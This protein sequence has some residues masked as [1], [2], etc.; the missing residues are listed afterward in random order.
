M[1]G[2]NDEVNGMAAIFAVV[3]AGV[4]VLGMFVFAIMVV[5]AAVL[6]LVA[7]VAWFKPLTLFGE[8]VQPEEARWFVYRGVIGMIGV[9]AFVAF[10]AALYG[11]HIDEEVWA[12]LYLGGYVVGS[13]GIEALKAINENE[14]VAV[15]PPSPSPLPPKQIEAHPLPKADP[16][17]FASWEDGDERQ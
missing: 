13:V 16:F 1:S 11:L 9:P 7:L 15:E 12:W 2:K 14:T 6:T 3:G 10:C 8:T 5:L 17:R 4:I